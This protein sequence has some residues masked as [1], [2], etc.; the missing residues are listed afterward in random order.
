VKNCPDFKL[1]SIIFVTAM[2]L[3]YQANA[4]K[5]SLVINGK[6]FHS[7]KSYVKERNTNI[8]FACSS[9][10]T[11]LDPNNIPADCQ[12]TSREVTTVNDEYN[13]NNRGFGLI[14]EFGKSHR[15]NYSNV[16]YVSAGSYLDSFNTVATYISG[17][18][19][20]YISIDRSLDNLHLE[21]G[22]V[23]SIINSPSYANG[24]LV[25]T[26]MP[27]VSLRTD[28]FGLN[29]TYLPKVSSETTGVFFIQLQ[30]ALT[31]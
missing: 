13:E 11:K 22:G 8:V 29:L 2:L 19:N 23:I 10:T 20:K 7:D 27:V 12:E 18:I 4:G 14:Y 16:P 30:L 17:G 5:L 1:V 31:H 9:T 28:T 3:P 15:S 25:A 6:S 24:N 21:L 26:V